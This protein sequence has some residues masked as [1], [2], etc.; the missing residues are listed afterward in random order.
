MNDPEPIFGWLDDMHQQISLMN[1]YRSPSGSGATPPRSIMEKQ[2][3]HMEIKPINKRPDDWTD[4]KAW[5]STGLYKPADDNGWLCL[6]T[7][8]SVTI[9][10]Q[11]LPKETLVNSHSGNPDGINETLLLKAIAAA[12]RAEVLK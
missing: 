1:Q 3:A 10:Y 12:S 6:V 11:G 5:P 9:L 7:D 4:V 2:F 8:D